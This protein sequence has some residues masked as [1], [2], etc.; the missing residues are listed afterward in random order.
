MSSKTFE[1]TVI[2]G[3][4]QLPEEVQLPENSRVWVT[5]PDE[6][7]PSPARIHTPRL[8]HPEQVKDFQ[9]DMQEAQDAG[10]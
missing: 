10:L 3:Q 2:N 4:I 9:M 7:E 1:A 8:V 6:A 5:V